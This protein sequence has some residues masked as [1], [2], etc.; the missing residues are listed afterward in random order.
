M[1]F[2]SDEE[3]T[4]PSPVEGMFGEEDSAENEVPATATTP[5]RKMDKAPEESVDTLLDDI[6]EEGAHSD[7]EVETPK[8]A[9]FPDGTH[10]VV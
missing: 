9:I 2:P 10:E 5:Q 4:G 8:K 1:W 3:D 7:V 6:L